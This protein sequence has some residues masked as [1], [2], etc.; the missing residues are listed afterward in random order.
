LISFLTG[1]ER[2]LCVGKGVLVNMKGKM[3]CLDA[4]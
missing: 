3:K 2:C 1:I 4:E